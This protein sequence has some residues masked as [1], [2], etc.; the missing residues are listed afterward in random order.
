MKVTV[1]KLSLVVLIGSSQS[2][3]S[4]FAKKHFHPD[5]VISE[6]V[7]SGVPNERNQQNLSQAAFDSI[8]AAAAELLALGQ[9]AVV[10]AANSNP[11]TRSTLLQLAKQYHCHSVAIALN[12]SDDAFQHRRQLPENCTPGFRDSHQRPSHPQSAH[13]ALKQEGFR[14]VFVMDSLEQ[15]AAATIEKVPLWNDQRDQ[16]GPFDIIG[17]VHGCCDEL[18]QL[19]ERLGYQPFPAENPAGWGNVSY[20]HPAGRK[21]F[22]VGDL[23]DRGPRVL[24]VLR[25][26]RSMIVRG[27]ALCVSGNHDVKLLRK[28]RGKNPRATHGL[29]ET[30]NEVEA[31]PDEVRGNFCNELALFLESLVSHYVLDDGKLVVAHAGLKESYQGRTSGKVKS[32]AIYG[33]T[34]GETDSFGMPVRRNW[35]AEYSGSAMVIYGHTPVAE[36]LWLNHTVNIDTGCVFGGKLTAMRY[37]EKEFISVPARRTYCQPSR[38]FLPDQ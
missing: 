36:P 3:Q 34:T 9:L 27:N 21:A 32:F 12:P 38:P 28:L 33:D 29:A 2:E 30:W 26:A 24:D 17:D 10:V 25:I 7:L 6:E 11:V 16:H 22:F 23:V 13:H 20:R 19:L 37:P 8:Q 4:L 14:H 35:A 31:L 5:E 18:E 1:P 15:I